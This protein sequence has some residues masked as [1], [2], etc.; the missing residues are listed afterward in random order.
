MPPTLIDYRNCEHEWALLR[1][2]GNKITEKC[3]KC[4]RC[5]N[6]IGIWLKKETTEGLL[7]DPQPDEIILLTP[8]LPL[9]GSIED[10]DTFADGLTKVIEE[11]D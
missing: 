3:K 9:E 4:R 6:R 2:G 10:P 8:G 5:R 7:K 1:C 11:Y